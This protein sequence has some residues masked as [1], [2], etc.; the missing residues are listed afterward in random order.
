MGGCRIG[1]PLLTHPQSQYRND[2]QNIANAVSSRRK[3][4]HQG[5]QPKPTLHALYNKEKVKTSIS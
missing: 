2:K 3:V 1:K 4:C 5:N